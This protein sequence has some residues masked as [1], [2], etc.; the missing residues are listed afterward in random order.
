MSSVDRDS[1]N[2]LYCFQGDEAGRRTKRKSEMGS[3]SC[4]ELQKK[5]KKWNT[6]R[7]IRS[8]MFC[9]G[10]WGHWSNSQDLI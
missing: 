6:D 3:G 9:P 7:V 1:T 4:E 5:E 2:F 10:Y 8:N